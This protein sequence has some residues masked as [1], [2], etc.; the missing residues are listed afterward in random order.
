MVNFWN[1]FVAMDETEAFH[2][3]EAW[4]LEAAVD[5]GDENSSDIVTIL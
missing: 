2:N 3:H 1:T 4:P 5:E